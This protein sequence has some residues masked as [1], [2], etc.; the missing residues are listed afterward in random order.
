M[1]RPRW[2]ETAVCDQLNAESGSSDYR[3]KE[4]IWRAVER[5]APAGRDVEQFC[6]S[7]GLN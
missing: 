1:G 4:S 7:F 3:M 2:I 6:D 5:G